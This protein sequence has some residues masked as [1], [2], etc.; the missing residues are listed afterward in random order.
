M[1]C[2]FL[3]QGALKVWKYPLPPLFDDESNAMGSFKL[4]PT[5]NPVN[6]LCR[7]YVVKVSASNVLFDTVKSQVNYTYFC[8]KKPVYKK[9]EAGT[10]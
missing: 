9:L 2:L 10:P 8:Y 7:V 4:L 3:M 1:S 6:L 5:M